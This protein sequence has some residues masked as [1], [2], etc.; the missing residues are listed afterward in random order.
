MTSFKWL[1]FL[2]GSLT[3]TNAPFHCIAFTILVLI[4]MVFFDILRD[5]LWDD[6]FKFSASAAASEF[7]EWVKGWD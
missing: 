2:L 6:T 1:T 5:A 3:V 4:G 7:C